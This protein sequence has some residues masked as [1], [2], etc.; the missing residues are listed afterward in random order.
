M[1]VKVQ[2]IYTVLIIAALLWFY[3][4]REHATGSGGGQ[5][6]RSG[7]SSGLTRQ[8]APIGPAAWHALMYPKQIVCPVSRPYETGG[9]TA[10]VPST[11]PSTW[12]L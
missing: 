3:S 1:K 8:R 6:R 11:V 4:R 10:T 2:Y 12:V 5:V 7:T 9:L